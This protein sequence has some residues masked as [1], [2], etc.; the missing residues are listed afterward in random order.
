MIDHSQIYELTKISIKEIKKNYHFLV[1][2]H[3]TNFTLNLKKKKILE[4]YFYSLQMHV[5]T[6]KLPL[7]NPPSE[8]KR[9]YMYMQ[10]LA[11][12]GVFFTLCG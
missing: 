1:Y 2:S 4:V 10:A 3:E 7:C 11:H 5:L 6:E 9:F 8:L 12:Y